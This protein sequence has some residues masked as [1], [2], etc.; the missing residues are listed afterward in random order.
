MVMLAGSDFSSLNSYYLQI[1]MKIGAQMRRI[2][3]SHA[4]GTHFEHLKLKIEMEI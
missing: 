2:I 1:K 4:L 3:I